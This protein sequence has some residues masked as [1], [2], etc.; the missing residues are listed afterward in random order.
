M[1]QTIQALN[2]M[3]K[4]DVIDTYAIAGAVAVLIHAEPVDTADL[5]VLVLLPETPAG[6]ATLRPIYD[7]LIAKGYTM[8]K[9]WF[10][11]EGVL[12]DFMDARSPLFREALD[13]AVPKTAW[14]QSI[15][16][17]RPEHLIAMFLTAGRTKDLIKIDIL[18]KSSKVN[19]ANIENVIR[20]HRLSNKWNRL[21]RRFY[22]F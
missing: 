22:G 5:D 21:M 16:V 12:V 15:R 6:L 17:V 11:I 19:K 9:Q 7:Y 14:G 4:D 2:K 3:V 20:R 1:K 13:K 10:D 18:L 8:H